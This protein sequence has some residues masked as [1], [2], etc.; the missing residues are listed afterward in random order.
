MLDE[1]LDSDAVSDDVEA[2]AGGAAP[3]GLSL[4][5][6]VNVGKEERIWGFLYPCKKPRPFETVF[7]G[8][9]GALVARDQVLE[10]VLPSRAVIQES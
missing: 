5:L 4:P 7:S 2:L 10:S 6:L 1:G 8:E 3:S 9:P